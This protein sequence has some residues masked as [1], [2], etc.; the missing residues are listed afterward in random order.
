MWA[1]VWGCGFQ[2]SHMSWHFLTCLDTFFFKDPFLAFSH[3]YLDRT[4]QNGQKVKWEPNWRG[5]WLG[6]VHEPELGA[7]E[8]Q[9]CHMSVCCPRG[10]QHQL[11]FYFAHWHIRHVKWK[12]VSTKEVFLKLFSH[13]QLVCNRYLEVSVYLYAE[14]IRL[15]LSVY[16]L[17]PIY[18]HGNYPEYLSNC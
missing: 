14:S 8:A 15:C 18:W 5:M 11:F 7:P 2:T 17:F 4:V 10:Y 3:F 13:L 9:Q 1:D 12:L 6:K 16:L